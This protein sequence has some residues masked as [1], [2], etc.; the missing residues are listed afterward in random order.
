M[1][2]LEQKSLTETMRLIASTKLDIV[3]GQ[4]ITDAKRRRKVLENG[5]GKLTEA[6]EWLEALKGEK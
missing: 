3:D 1:T 5:N 6:W 4:N 2:T